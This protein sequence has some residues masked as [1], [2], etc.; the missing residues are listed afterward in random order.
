MLRGTIELRYKLI[1]ERIAIL[2]QINTQAMLIVGT[3][4]GLLSAESLESLDQLRQKSLWNWILA[5]SFVMLALCRYSL[6]YGRS[7]L[8]RSSSNELR[9][10]A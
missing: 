3:S 2:N 1:T 8:R 4:A 9:R 6:P 7:T 10:R 5:V